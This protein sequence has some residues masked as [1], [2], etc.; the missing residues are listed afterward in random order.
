LALREDALVSC[1]QSLCYCPTPG[2][3]KILESQGSD[4]AVMHC[5]S[6]GASWCPKC[7]GH[8]HWPASCEHRRWWDT[9]HGQLVSVPAENAT[10]KQ[11]P[12]C[13]V[14]IE[15]NGGCNHMRCRMCN[16]NFCWQ[17]GSFSTGLA[18]H[19]VNVPCTPNVWWTGD[20]AFGMTPL[21]SVPALLTLEADARASMTRLKN[22][23][24]DQCQKSLDVSMQY[25]SGL[26]TAAIKRQERNMLEARL[27]L[28]HG[29]LRKHLNKAQNGKSV[30]DSVNQEKL[31]KAFRAL[32]AYISSTTA[33]LRAGR[34]L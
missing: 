16:V 15:K 18:Y 32:E 6:C 25:A 17:C 20:L 29:Q 3:G 1:S 11:C 4:V 8:A 26:T 14:E 19:Q 2:C 12:S 23:A 27:L 24:S 28:M 13:F 22:L 21:F 33:F 34:Q 7:K 31:E 9:N 5:T 10:N 30:D